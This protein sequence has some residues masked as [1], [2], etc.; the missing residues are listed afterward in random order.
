MVQV[1]KAAG[2]PI[3]TPTPADLT[4]GMPNSIMPRHEPTGTEMVW[5]NVVGLTAVFLLTAWMTLA[6]YWRVSR[7]SVGSA[8]RLTLDEGLRVGSPAK[9]IA[10]TRGSQD[11]HLSFRGTYV[12]LVFGSED[13]APCGELITSA[14]RHPATRGMR[15]IYLSNIDTPS[16]PPTISS[17]WEV[18]KF[19]NELRTR[20]QWHVPVSP[21]FH[22]IDPSGRV[23]AKGVANRMGHLDRLLG[24][25]PSHLSIVS[26]KGGNS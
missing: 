12:F 21:Y 23:A 17:K 13:C 25:S 22:V 10:C 2:C 7:W 14:S 16:I 19:H 15:H 4:R 18:Y 5:P 11:F 20:K 26:V 6:L 8:E 24:L 1:V 3:R 9:E